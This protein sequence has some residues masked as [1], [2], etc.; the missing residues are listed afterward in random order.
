MRK[1]YRAR[2][3]VYLFTLLKRVRLNSSSRCHPFLPPYRAYVGDNRPTLIACGSLTLLPLGL[4]SG[5]TAVAAHLL[6]R[7]Q[8]SKTAA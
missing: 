1:M 5:V 4:A 6:F 8:A 3:G 2:W 7:G